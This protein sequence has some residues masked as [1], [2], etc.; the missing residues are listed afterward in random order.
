MNPLN[1]KLKWFWEAKEPMR[2]GSGLISTVYQLYGPEPALLWA[3]YL[4]W[5]KVLIFSLS[6]PS[7]RIFLRV[8]C[9]ILHGNSL[10]TENSH[11][12]I[13]HL[14]LD[15][16]TWVQ[17]SHNSSCCFSVSFSWL[18]LKHRG[19]GALF[20][21]WHIQA[22]GSDLVVD[23]SQLPHLLTAGYWQLTS[24]LR[25]QIFICKM[26][27]RTAFGLWDSCEHQ[28]ENMHKSLGASW[29][30]SLT[31]AITHIAPVLMFIFIMI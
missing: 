22:L 15:Y 24:P 6:L 5:K 10:Q 30:V 23:K 28:W 8:K 27:P 17:N 16:K 14:T 4:F 2:P 20:L 12:D 11:Y 31:P 1:A 25:A 13:C 18:F 3:S 26:G 29:S 9:V 7:Y 19:E 21:I